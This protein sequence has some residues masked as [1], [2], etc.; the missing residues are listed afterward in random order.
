MNDDPIIAFFLRVEKDMRRDGHGAMV[1]RALQNARRSLI[2]VLHAELN[3]RRE[4]Q[5]VKGL[6]QEAITPM[7]RTAERLGLLLPY[8]RVPVKP[9]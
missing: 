5:F 2:A 8:L 4:R 1:D 9:K 7:T 3:R 6:I